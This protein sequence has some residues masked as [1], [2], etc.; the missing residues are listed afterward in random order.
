M[1]RFRT[2]QAHLIRPGDILAPR[3]Y[4][5]SSPPQQVHSTEFLGPPTF[6]I[7]I[8]MTDGTLHDFA[9]NEIVDFPRREDGTIKRWTSPPYAYELCI[10]DWLPPLEPKPTLE[11]LLEEH[12]QTREKVE[13]AGLE[14]STP[15]PTSYHLAQ[16]TDVWQKSFVVVEK[17]RR[18]TRADEADPHLM[19]TV[20]NHFTEE[21]TRFIVRASW[22]IDLRVIPRYTDAPTN[23]VSS[24]VQNGHTVSGVY[25]HLPTETYYRF[26]DRGAKKPGRWPKTFPEFQ[27]QFDE[28]PDG[29]PW[30]MRPPTNIHQW[31]ELTPLPGETRHSNDPNRTPDV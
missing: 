26:Y 18:W 3:T 20:R 10:G 28:S 13:A 4:Q 17:V 23:E 19:L 25:K 12:R 9:H 29:K 14:Y 2:A 21:V 27:I 11:A 15:E 16:L 1:A 24:V 30:V 22:K 8:R 5:V 7:R 6:K 31:R